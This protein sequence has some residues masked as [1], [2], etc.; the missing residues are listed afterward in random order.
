M[1]LSISNT[2][3]FMTKPV[4]DDRIKFMRRMLDPLFITLLKAAT[5]VSHSLGLQDA[6]RRLR[7]R[8][9]KAQS[10]V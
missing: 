3:Q 6:E 7:L 9:A 10:E 8:E 1:S 2:I 4:R 5:P